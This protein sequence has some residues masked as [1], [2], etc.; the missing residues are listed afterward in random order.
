MWYI[1]YM[2]TTKMNLWTKF[3]K[4]I[5]EGSANHEGYVVCPSCDKMFRWQD[6]DCG[7][8]IENTERK[9]DFGGNALW[10]DKR[11]FAAQCKQCNY[12]GT[13]QAKRH[14]TVKFIAKH[15]E[16]VYNELI[17]L[18]QTPKKWTKEEVVNIIENLTF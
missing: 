17:K 15:G 1:F 5:R 4:K 6:T 11:N 12:F 13:A 9:K 14:W 10:Y 8:F 2:P 16:D 3:S 7:H 18:K